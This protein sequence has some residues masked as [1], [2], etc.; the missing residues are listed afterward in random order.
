[1]DIKK[2][3]IK[4]VYKAFPQ[5]PK[6]IY[7][8]LHQRLGDE[9]P[10]AVFQVGN[11]F[12]VWSHSSDNWK[13]MTAA[14]EFKQALV[15]EA[16]LQMKDRI[17]SSI[18]PSTA[19]VLFLTPDDSYIFYNDDGGDIKILITGWGFKKPVRVLGKGS[20]YHKGKKKL[21]APVTVSFL[22]DGVALPNYKFGYKAKETVNPL[23]TDE[24]GIFRFPSTLSHGIYTLV[25]TKTNREY[26]LNVVDGQSHYDIDV[27]Q[28]ATV[29]FSANFDGYPIVGETVQVNYHGKPYECT[30][31][32]NGRAS[33]RL[34]FYQGETVEA[35]L[36]DQVKSLAVQEGDNAIDFEFEA[37]VI[38][39]DLKV[40]VKEGGEPVPNMPVRVN[41]GGQTLD[42]MSDA[43]GACALH[44]Q[45]V[46]G[47]TCTV[48]VDGYPDDS[49]LLEED[50]ENLFVFDKEK[51]QEMPPIP[52][53]KVQPH[54]KVEGNDGFIGSR[55]PIVVEYGGQKYPCTTDDNGIVQLPE[56]PCGTPVRVTDGIHADNVTD[57][58]LEEGQ[59]EL[60][61]H[62]PYDP[63]M[64]NRDIK[65]MIRDVQGKPVM[66]EKVCFRQGANERLVQLDPQG[67][68]Y[69]SK[70]AFQVGQPIEVLLI[71]AS[72]DYGPINFT[73]DEGETEYLLQENNKKNSPW[74]VVLEILLVLLVIVAL[75]AL[76][77]YLMLAFETLYEMI[78]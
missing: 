17:T 54:I 5:N 34:P 70:D 30:T 65:V 50:G 12:Y 45:L 41:Y 8:N 36:R 57:Y 1:M 2:V 46:P 4:D 13:Q 52:L 63:N 49:K 16:M 32:A 75:F 23:E 73:M 20:E 53:V 68:T 25:D 74:M 21:N 72:K 60:L 43:M 24:N 39:T 35:S 18:G 69:F 31:D 15:R 28:F 77:P 37:D 47:A 3:S 48:S 6:E 62:I 66:C 59:D 55:Y 19:E 22:H 51:V 76:W 61:F 56:M 10:F 33:L 58:V 27:T 44:V 26:V 29:D 78:Y 64:E 42:A 40:V 7:N 14:D 11:G 38:E 67:D 71:G 9:N